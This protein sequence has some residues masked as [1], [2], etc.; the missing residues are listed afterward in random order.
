M[1]SNCDFKHQAIVL[2]K[3]DKNML[4]LDLSSIKNVA[5]IGPNAD[6][7][8]TLLGN[9]YGNPPFIVT[10]LEALSNTEVRPFISLSFLFRLKFKQGHQCIV[11]YGL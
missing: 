3:N 2:L 7:P 5:V 1:M 6:S 10:P 8:L 9:Y 11:F 4:P